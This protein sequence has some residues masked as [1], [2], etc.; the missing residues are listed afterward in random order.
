VKRRAFS[1][2]E[3]LVVIGIIAVLVA[4]VLPA[5]HRVRAAAERA[6]CMSKL[7]QISLALH[8]YHGEH[9][10]LPPGCS[11]NQRKDPYPFMSWCTR[12]LPYLDQEALWQQ[13]KEAYAINRAYWVCPPHVGNRPQPLFTCPS[14]VREIYNSPIGKW[15]QGFTDYLG[16]EG[17]NQFV[18][19]G[20]LYLDSKVELAHVTDGTSHTVVVGERPPFTGD[21]NV[22][23]LGWWYAGE[24][25]DKDGSAD[26]V[27]GAREYAT[28]GWLHHCGPESNRFQP[29]RQT[30][31]CD[32]LHFWSMH[33]GGANFLF[34]DS[35]VRFLAYS[36]DPILPALATRAG[37]EPVEL[38]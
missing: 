22:N 19:D 2:V 14:Q 37:G 18:K 1:L 35:S 13:A 3:V 6:K 32:Q 11:Y 23:F 16:V 24:G 21:A 25:Q 28:H 15:T 4:I 7:E 29:G 12:L 31:E 9:G 38:P 36:A 20:V 34:A 33:S 17:T 8:M 5:I 27:L 10:S 30:N 26:M